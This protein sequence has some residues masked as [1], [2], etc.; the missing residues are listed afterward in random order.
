MSSTIGLVMDLG[1]QYTSGE[2]TMGNCLV[3]ACEAPARGGVYCKNCAEI[4][5]SERVGAR[6]AGILARLFNDRMVAQNQIDALIKE[7]CE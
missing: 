5:L 4:R 2:H 3:E 6:N 7:V 1:Y